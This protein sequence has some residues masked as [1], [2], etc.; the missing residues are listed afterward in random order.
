MPNL[1]TARTPVQKAS[2]QI[3]IVTPAIVNLPMRHAFGIG[4]GRTLSVVN[5][6][7]RKSPVTITMT[8]SSGVRIAWP[9]MIRPAIRNIT[10]TI[11]LMMAFSA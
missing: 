10:V 7:E 2:R 5:D 11:F 8:I 1:P 9:V 6:I 3:P 4:D